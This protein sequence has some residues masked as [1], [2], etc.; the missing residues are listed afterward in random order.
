MATGS[1]VIGNAVPLLRDPLRFLTDMYREMGPVYRISAGPQQFTI[2]AGPEAAEFLSS[3]VGKKALASD[4]A[5]E[6]FVGEFGAR[7]AVVST[8]GV[9]HARLRRVLGP[10]FSAGALRG[11]MDEVANAIDRSL[12]E[13]LTP[14]EAQPALP[15]MQRLAIDVTGTVFTGRPPEEFREPIRT[16]LRYNLN[17]FMLQKWPRLVL[18]LPRYRDAKRR[19]ADLARILESRSR[20]VLAAGQRRRGIV[21]DDIIDAHQNDPALIPARDVAMNLL[22]PYMVGVETL[23]ATSTAL[24]HHLLAN[25]PVLHQVVAE[26]DALF[27]AVPLP[28]DVAD[29]APTL[30]NAL[31]EAMRLH[32]P[33]LGVRRTVAEDFEFHG[34]LVCRGDTVIVGLAVPHFLAEYYPEPYRFDVER[35][36]QTPSQYTAASGIFNP[37][38]R[39]PHMC[40][41]MKSTE[42]LVCASI[43]RLLNR[44]EIDSVAEEFVLPPGKTPDVR[45]RRSFEIRVRPRRE[46]A[47]S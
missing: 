14:G 21:V 35:G 6:P 18:R 26:S 12:D 11:R 10:G 20:A 47:A 44:F 29:R 17:V 7:T 23:A 24:L 31:L 30:Y 40:L 37:F 5:W 36:R 25:P 39:G 33:A 16:M 22:S 3:D 15:T 42:V 27:G 34:H 4:P 43:A 41:G 38:G 19:T 28:E 9:E 45:G 13:H 2:L 46:V 1:R 32:P 8:D